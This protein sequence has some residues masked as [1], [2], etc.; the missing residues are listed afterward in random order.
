MKKVL[1]GLAIDN[2]GSQVRVIRY[3]GD[4]AVAA[5]KN[6]FVTIAEEN[7]RVKE[8]ENGL[9]LCRFVEAPKQEYLGIIARGLA[10]KM[11]DG[12]TLTITSQRQKT[13]STNY[14]RQ[15]LYGVAVSAIQE[16]DDVALRDNDAM[17]QYVIVTCIPIREHSGNKDCAQL[18]RANLAGEYVVEFP[19]LEGCPRVR[20]SILEKYVL[21]APEGGVAVSRLKGAVQPTDISLLI[22]MGEVSTEL[23]IA[24]GTSI[25]GKVDTLT[26]AGSTLNANVRMALEDEGYHVSEAQIEQV[27]VT[28]VVNRGMTTIDVSD[29][30][31]KQKRLFVE[32][33]MKPKI[34]GFLLANQISVDQVQ[35]IVP[36]GAPLNPANGKTTIIDA[37]KESCGMQQADVKLLA[38]DLRYVNIESIARFLKRLLAQA[39]E[40]MGAE[41]Y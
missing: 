20:F 30:I 26:A 34:N 33:Y 31:E 25:V 38:E 35:H 14:Y 5:Y 4:Q 29:I 24:E 13:S 21:A 6:D 16:L 2:G 39:V 36:L 32:N 8:C 12:S 19:L 17:I 10:G 23:G 40:S 18:L 41:T 28:G 11:Y 3:N 22:D 37:I 15:F 7:F 27:M 1:K 9:E